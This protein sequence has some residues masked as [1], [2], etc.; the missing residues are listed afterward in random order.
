MKF[1]AN[2]LTDKPFV[3]TELY[4]VVNDKDKLIDGI[5]TLVIGWEYTKKIY[6]NANILNWEIDRN[7]YWTYGKR[8]KRN[9]Y[10]ENLE[11]FRELALYRFIKS[12]KYSYFNI[13]IAS[14]EEKEYVWSLIDTDGTY[15]YLNNDMVYAFDEQ[16]NK[17][18]G[19]SLRDIDYLKKDRKKVLSKIYSNTNLIEVKDNLSWETKNALRNCSYV[20]PF[21]WV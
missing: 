20:I 8:E 1:I 11:K 21:L 15:V 18:I 16:E 13:L 6:E 17:V 19:F 12:V 7:T 14:N 3:N 4:N 9:R 5:P 2:I 10:E